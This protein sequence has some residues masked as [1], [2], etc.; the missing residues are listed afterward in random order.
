V[1][2]DNAADA[3][4]QPRDAAPRLP[5]GLRHGRRE[6]KL[7]CGFAER[8]HPL[9][10]RSAR[11]AR[12]GLAGRGPIVGLLISVAIPIVLRGA[13]LDSVDPALVDTAETAIC[14]V[15]CM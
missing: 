11:V 9:T 7:T 5:V 12:A 15:G 4:A 10:F 3:R 13:D 2:D 8:T 14:A 1:I 6:M